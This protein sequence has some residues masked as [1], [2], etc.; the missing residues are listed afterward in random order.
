MKA[1]IRGESK[2]VLQEVCD[3]LASEELGIAV[4]FMGEKG[5]IVASSR[6]GRIGQFHEIAARI[7]T[8]EFDEYEV[9]AD[10]ATKSRVMLPGWNIAIDV[11]G[12]RLWSLSL[13]TTLPLARQYARIA[14]QWTISRIKTRWE[15]NR[16][17]DFAEVASD[18]FWEADEDLRWT[19][20]SERFQQVT[21]IAPTDLIGKTRREV[22]IG[23]AEPESWNQ[24]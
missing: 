22:G 1:D 9:T 19:Y 21:G 13:T 8:G 7:M 2:E 6:R 14:R 10:M 11:N 15:Q 24:H 20:F 12:V 23:S 3:L 17:R 4:S 5:E 18:W 16:L